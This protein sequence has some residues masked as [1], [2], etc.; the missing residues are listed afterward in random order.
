[1]TSA[2]S[3]TDAD[4]EAIREDYRGV[5]EYDS[6]PRLLA[7]IDR[8]RTLVLDLYED[9]LCTFDHH[10][11]CQEHGWFETEPACPHS[12]I[13]AFGLNQDRSESHG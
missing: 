11:Y 2:K 7:E 13:R 10:G 12:R 9:S 4:L 3:L 1:M 6:V 8:L 5:D